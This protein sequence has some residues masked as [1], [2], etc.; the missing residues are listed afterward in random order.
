MPTLSSVMAVPAVA[1]STTNRSMSDGRS[2]PSTVITMPKMSM[3]RHA[4]AKTWLRLKSFTSGLLPEVRAFRRFASGASQGLCV[5][6][7]LSRPEVPYLYL[8][9]RKP[10]VHRQHRA[11]ISNDIGPAGGEFFHFEPIY[12][13]EE[14]TS[15]LQSRE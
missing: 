14:H 15:E 2:V 12:R 11:R 9:S 3:P 5:G 7:T 6:R 10:N 8:L 1:V 13:S 4:A